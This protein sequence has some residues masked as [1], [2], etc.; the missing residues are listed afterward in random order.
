M[1]GTKQLGKV[2]SI[3]RPLERQCEGRPKRLDEA[4]H[5][6]RGKAG[7]LLLSELGR[8]S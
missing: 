3:K 8:R 5:I 2:R 6:T 4:S 7:T 1:T